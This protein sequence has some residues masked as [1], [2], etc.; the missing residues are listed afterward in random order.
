[1][2]GFRWF[3]ASAIALIAVPAL[4]QTA[5]FSPQR[6]SKHVQVLGSDAFEGRAPA[7]AG[8]TKT[9]KYLSDQFRAAG[10]QPGGDLVNGK[11]QWTQAVPLLRSEWNAN[12][13][14]IMTIAGKATPLAQG[15]Q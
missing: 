4:S 15:E 5:T 3:A 12:P 13:Q 10:V 2:T 1:M 8:E 14:V 11:R 6:L 7:T 9:V